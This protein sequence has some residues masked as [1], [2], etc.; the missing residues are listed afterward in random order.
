MGLNISN[1]FNSPPNVPANTTTSSQTNAIDKLLERQNEI[2]FGVKQ[3]RFV[4]G[5]NGEMV[6]IF[7]A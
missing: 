3:V 4:L 6:S 2:R 1:P 7:K 5:P